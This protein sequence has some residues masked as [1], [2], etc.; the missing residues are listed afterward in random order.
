MTSARVVFVAT[1]CPFCGGSVPLRN[2]DTA[3]SSAADI[4][5]QGAG[6]QLVCWNPQCEKTFWVRRVD[7]RIRRGFVTT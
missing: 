5:T 3:D 1:T 7:L 4:T 6:Q 2:D